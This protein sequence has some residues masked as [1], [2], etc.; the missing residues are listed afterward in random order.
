MSDAEFQ[1]FSSAVVAL[2]MLFRRKFICRGATLASLFFATAVIVVLIF[3]EM[4]A[5][6]SVTIGTVGA[7]YLIVDKYIDSINRRIV[8]NIC[9]LEHLRGMHFDLPNGGWLNK[10][11]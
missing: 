8:E 1:K 6:V 5:H 2:N 7:G 3:F 9:V 10:E 11:R 4:F